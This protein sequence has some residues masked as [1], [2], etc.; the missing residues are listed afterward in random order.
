M[1][2]W[3]LLYICPVLETVEAKEIYFDQLEKSEK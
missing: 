1:S 2:K 3:H